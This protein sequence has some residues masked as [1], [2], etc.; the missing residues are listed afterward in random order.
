MSDEILRLI[1]KNPY[2]IP[3]SERL[4]NVKKVL[5][6]FC[7]WADNVRVSLEQNVVFVDQGEN[8]ERILCPACHSELDIDWWQE[9]MGNAAESNFI[10]LRVTLPCCKV[11][12]SLNEL[13]YEWPAGFA[14][15]IIEATNPTMEIDRSK[16]ELLETTLGT[17]FRTLDMR[18]HYGVTKTFLEP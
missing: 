17:K 9:E 2:F 4:S 14:Q 6:S 18:W 7:H 12:T 5:A 3:S 1:P 16:L 8:F 11:D 15:F 10:D 13:I